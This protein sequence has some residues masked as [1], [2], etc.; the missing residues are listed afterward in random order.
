MALK[1]FAKVLRHF[2]KDCTSWKGPLL[3]QFLK[4]CILW[5]GSTLEM[6]MK[7]CFLWERPHVGATFNVKTFQDT[8]GKAGESIYTWIQR[9]QETN[10]V[11]SSLSSFC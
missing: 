2:L 6:F 7:D 1:L 5:N 4:S 9:G 8:G 10:F 3:E 11:F